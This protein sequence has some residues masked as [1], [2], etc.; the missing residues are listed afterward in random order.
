[1][2]VYGELEKGFVRFELKNS[3]EVFRNLT[4]RDN[5]WRKYISGITIGS[6][7]YYYYSLDD[8][9]RVPVFLKYKSDPRG[10]NKKWIRD[11]N[12]SSLEELELIL[13]VLIQ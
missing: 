6:E 7:I 8:E 4:S 12:C 1:M 5:N 2:Q 3:G 13:T 10:D 9:T 11:L